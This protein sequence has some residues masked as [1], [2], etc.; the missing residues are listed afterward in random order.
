MRENAD[1]LLKRRTPKALTGQERF[2]FKQGSLIRPRIDIEIIS[3][4][5]IAAIEVVPG[6]KIGQILDRNEV[7][8]TGKQINSSPYTFRLFPP[9]RI[10]WRSHTESA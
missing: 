6:S 4:D 9:A 8:L 1:I 2:T 5:Q 7:I 3:Q 10:S